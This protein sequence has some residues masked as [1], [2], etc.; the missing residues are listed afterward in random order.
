ME[1]TI[2]ILQP[3]YLPWLGFFDQVYSCD[4]FILYDDVQ[5]DKYGWRNRNKIKTQDGEHWLT[6]PVLHKGLGKQLIKDVKINYTENWVVKHIKSITQNYSKTPFFK[7][8][9]IDIFNCLNKKYIYLS[10]LTTELIYVLCKFLKIET[11]I[12]RSS[13]LK[14]EGDRIQR[15][16][17]C[18]KY[19][20][21]NKFIE[22]TA[23]KDYICKEVFDKNGIKVIY[24]DY[25]HPEYRQLYSS[26]VCN[27]SV[28]DLIFNCGPNSLLI[29]NNQN[30]L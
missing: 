3:G 11:S 18:I 2:G 22:G 27:L 12:V 21:G 19:F 8:Y 17:Q 10:D 20:N 25:K 28:I 6:V 23:G 16:I 7:E 24:Q 13:T 30:T 1:K 5:F 9:S 4:V 29:L 26:F 15:L 14:L